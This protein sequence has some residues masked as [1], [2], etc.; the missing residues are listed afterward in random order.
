MASLKVDISVDDQ[1]LIAQLDRFPHAKD[2]AITRALN[3]TG[4]W[5]KTR[6]TN[7]A[8]E[9]LTVKR[10]DISKSL[11]VTR[12]RPDHQLAQVKMSGK[13]ISLFKFL[14]K[15]TKAPTRHGIS[16]QISPAEGRKTIEH[17]AF[18]AV[19]GGITAFFKRASTERNWHVKVI[20]KSGKRAGKFIWSQN[21]INK[22]FGPSTV[23]V[24][25]SSPAFSQLATVGAAERL[26]LQI[27][28]EINFLLTGSSK[29][30]DGG[31]S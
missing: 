11:S 3:R 18:T 4:D 23:K 27:G 6:M 24:V 29:G 28:R 9:V 13:R 16:Y 12:A 22:L 19:V 1:G 2:M 25:E 20:A 5:V 17:N 15:P 30:T 26:E 10:S 21:K 14:G 31:A 7:I 8:D